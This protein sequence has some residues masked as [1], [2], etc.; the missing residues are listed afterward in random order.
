MKH[1]FL[2]VVVASLLAVPA[3]HAASAQAAQAKTPQSKPAAQAQPASGQ[4]H[5]VNADFVSY[6]A[7]TK[8]LMVKDDKGQTS[9]APLEG[10]AIREVTQLH[11]KA[12][13]H[14]MLTCR[15]NAKGQHQAVTEIKA[16]KAKG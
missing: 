8:M 12:G 10:R 11:L 2:S 6:D 16:A 4:T 5:L 3:L 1:G 9:S 14:V 7:K 15:D 13:D